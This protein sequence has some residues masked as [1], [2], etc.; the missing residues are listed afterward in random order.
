MAAA[1]IIDALTVRRALAQPVEVSQNPLELD[2]WD[3]EFF[4][5]FEMKKNGVNT[6]GTKAACPV[7]YTQDP[8]HA[9]DYGS[10]PPLAATV[11]R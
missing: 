2:T 8:N 11:V 3:D 7:F 6:V 9:V 5:D 4:V 10:Y 1:D